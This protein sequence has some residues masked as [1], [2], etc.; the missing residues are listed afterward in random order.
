MTGRKHCRRPAA[1]L[2]AALLLAV[3]GQVSAQSPQPPVVLGPVIAPISGGPSDSTRVLNIAPRTNAPFQVGAFQL[4]GGEQVIVVSGGVLLTIRNVQ[5]VGLIDIEAEQLVFWTRGDS[6]NALERLRS[7]DG[8]QAQEQEFFLSGDVQIRSQ[9]GTQQRKLRADQVYYDVRRNVAVA[10]NGDLEMRDP[11]LPETLHLKGEELFQLGPKRFEADNA[12][13]FASRLPSDPG[14]KVKFNHASIE[15]TEYERRTLFGLPLAPNQGPVG[16]RRLVRGEQAVLQVEGV[17]VFYLPVLQTEA[18]EP[19]GPLKTLSFRQDQIFGTQLLTSF[20]VYSLLGVEPIPNTRWSFLLDYLSKRGPATGTTYQYFGNELFGLQG[21]FAGE[22]RL[23]GIYDSGT[24]ILGGG[25]GEIDGHPLLRGRVLA[26][27]Q[28]KLFDDFLFQYQLGLQSDKNYYEQY[29]KQ[30]FDNELNQNTWLYLKYQRDYYAATAT[31]QPHLRDWLTETAWLPRVDG[32]ALGVSFLDLFTY[33]V[34]GSAGY[35][36]L[37]PTSVPPPPVINPNTDVSNNTGRFDVWQD[38]SLP[39]YLG[40]VKVVPYGVLDLTAYTNDLNGD[41]TGRVYGG[42]G[43]RGSMPLTRVYPDVQSELFNVNAINHKIVLSSNYFYAR[44][45]E[46]YTLFAQLDRLNDDATDQALRDITPRQPALNPAAG[47][48]LA[49]SPIFNPQLYAIRRLVD[50]RADTLDDMQVI[51]ADIRQRWQTKRGYPGMQ[52]VVDFFTLDLSGS[53][54]P[55]PNQD[56]FGK[57]VAFLEYDAQWNVGDRTAL[58]STGYYDPFDNGAR[59]ITIGAFLSRPDRTNFFVGY[60][61]T[62]PIDSRALTGAVTYIFSPKYAITAAST[63]DFGTELAL[64]NSL[65]ITRM[66][67]DLAVSFGF[68]YNAILNNFGFT[69][70]VV[71][72]IVAISRARVTPAPFGVPLFR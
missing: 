49:T 27:H 53:F 32:T 12:E 48:A 23:Y 19:L 43:V 52:H 41:S 55:Q 65:V 15:E 8:L 64:S 38:L 57:T 40:P 42:G 50:N 4:P 6:N 56:N 2:A 5:G 44:S 25:R 68:T 29:F 36:R 16:Q 10:T 58:V 66:G 63:Y 54:F 11:K 69:L 7:S 47:T 18:E 3:A 37:F 14:L 22:V 62:D 24:D 70:E 26:R 1:L 39:F 9:T 72:N 33:N 34:R 17:P 46:P 31:V 51:Q 28:Q 35:G 13:V 59:Q 71:P 67:T 21:P 45:N 30:E 60:R 61:A 20:N